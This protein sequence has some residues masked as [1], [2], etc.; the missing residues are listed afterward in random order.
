MKQIHMIRWMGSSGIIA[1]CML[2]LMSIQPTAVRAQEGVAGSSGDATTT[3]AATVAT[4]DA[5]ATTDQQNEVN[6]NTAASP[7]T[8]ANSSVL[9]DGNENA[10]QVGTEST[11]TAQTGEN[12][13]SGLDASSSVDSGDAIAAS[14]VINVVNTNI[15][16]SIGLILFLNQLFGGAPDL[17]T[18]DLSYFLGSGATTTCSFLSCGASNTENLIDTNTATVTNEMLVR[19]ATGGNDAQSEGGDASVASGNAY[20]AANLVNLVN[21]NILDSQ[22]LLVSFNN[23]GN[24]SGDITL[25]DADFFE[26]LFARG[27]SFAG[28]S[29]AASVSTDNTVA[30]TGT[31]TA[32]AETGDNL[33]TTTSGTASVSTGSAYAGSSE[34]TQANQTLV[35]GTS[36]YLLFRVWGNW[37]GSV[38][39]LPD[40]ITW[41]QT[42]SGVELVGNSTAGGPAA[43]LGGSSNT[44]NATTSNAAAL[45]N[46]VNVWA[47]TGGNRAQADTGNASIAS[48]NAY[49]AASVL[50]MVNTTILGR[51]WIFAI[52]NIFGDWK[53][54]IA[55]GHPDL[56]VGAAAQVAGPVMPG[57]FV[58]YH[59]TVVNK[60]D[61]DATDVKLNMKFDNGGLVVDP[62]DARAASA[63]TVEDGTTWN[64]GTLRKGESRDITYRAVARRVTS[65]G[66][67]PVQMTASI[68]SAQTDENA[69]DNTDV[70][71]VA[72]GDPPPLIG[73]VGP[74][75]WAIEPKVTVEREVSSGATVASS[76]VDFTVVVR[77][78]K[79]AGPAFLGKLSDSIVGP[80][81]QP[82]F[83]RSWNLGTIAPGDEIRLSY[84]IAFGTSTPLGEYVAQAEVTAREKN[85][86][87]LY[88]V[89][90][91]AVSSSATVELVPR[92]NPIL[93]R[94]PEMKTVAATTIESSIV[95]TSTSAVSRAIASVHTV[96]KTKS[97]NYVSIAKVA[98]KS[99]GTPREPG[100][101]GT[102]NEFSTW[103][104]AWTA[105]ILA[106]P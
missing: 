60:G 8:E 89:D 84:T 43:L 69:I 103:L 3:A 79:D 31:T 78:A 77:N 37:S 80:D 24:L 99:Y 94:L 22:Y 27:S 74:G 87:D 36:V 71:A 93:V 68:S 26:Q 38:Q 6:T 49:A 58:T 12:S 19:A 30:I 105:Q 44:L 40:G 25:P 35:G 85:P 16:D 47:L 1:L 75:P 33:A 81:G 18:L 42:P 17:R 14:N 72:V 45:A 65:K 64:L 21:T 56:W 15:F 73:G 28:N 51:N 50:N 2:T 4:G 48:G 62:D 57:N 88:A 92:G 54:D 104:A 66:V 32:N 82:L 91:P 52:F 55:F 29:N 59:F 102:T 9:S 83:S 13:A 67:V 96:A 76:T 97:G 53:G 106:S 11:T 20:A 7:Q 70:L 46:N 100:A 34:F 101:T 5:T 90:M 61:A 10:A 98:A 95:A 41:K 86:V 23:F 39:G 63:S